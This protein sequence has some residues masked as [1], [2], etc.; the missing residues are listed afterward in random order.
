ML[1][2]SGPVSDL[3]ITNAR[4]LRAPGEQPSEPTTVAVRAGLISDDPVPGAPNLD[5]GGGVVT[6]GFWNCHVHLTEPTWAGAAHKDRAVLQAGLDDMFGERGFTAVV[7][8]ASNSRDTLPL[9]RRIDSGEL[10]G[11]RILTA[12]E[13]IRPWRGLPFYTKEAVPWFLWWALPAPATAWGAGR[14]ARRQLAKGA[15][16]IKLFTGSYVERDRIKPMRPGPAGAAVRAAHD[17]GALTFAH[18]SN[19]VGLEVALDADV[20][21][22]AHVPDETDGTE[23]LLRAA[24]DR[25]VW[26]VPTLDMFAQT[27]TRDRSYLDAIHDALRSFIADGG[28]LLFGTDVGYL[29]DHDTR[30]ELAALAECGLGVAD[31]LRMLTTHPSA[32]LGHGGGTVTVGEPADLVVLERLET[33]TDL[34]GVRATIRDGRTIWEAT[35]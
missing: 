31:V 16:V 26:L 7:D 15:D 23:G 13:A 32:A 28:H 9:R 22:I 11:P 8:L 12:T 35:R 14:A 29:A 1:C 6:A 2:E 25:G 4:V 10:H 34:A 19:R 17:R 30:G 20:D 27:V 5:A 3:L 18:T 24:A 21:V 33:V